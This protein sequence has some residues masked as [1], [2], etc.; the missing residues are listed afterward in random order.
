MCRS[1]S[2]Q[3]VR[4]IVSSPVQ[5]GG[6]LPVNV[7]FCRVSFDHHEAQLSHG[8][9]SQLCHK[10]MPQIRIAFVVPLSLT[11]QE[12]TIRPDLKV[13]VLH[14]QRLPPEAP[15]GSRPGKVKERFLTLPTLKKTKQQALRNLAS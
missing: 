1:S 11:L 3:C 7:D 2:R 6:D 8:F 12:T 10:I 13:S 15:H 4:S 5:S 14:S 9:Q